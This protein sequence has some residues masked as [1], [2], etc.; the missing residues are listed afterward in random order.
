MMKLES[1]VLTP[2]RATAREFLAVVF[3]RRWIILGLFGVTMA[4][5]LVIA[6]GTPVY[7]V[8]SGQVLVRRGEQLSIMQPWRAVPND[9]EVELGSE[10]HTVKSWPV[11]ER[12][13][14]LLDESRRR[15]PAIKV[16]ETQV[17]AEVTGKSN[18]LAI[19]YR[20]RDPRV[21]ERVCDA[22][23]RAYIEYRQG[24][25]LS[26]P[27]HF[28][29]SEISQADSQMQRLTEERRQ[30]ANRTGMVDLPRQRENLI[31]L[32]G[33]LENR[34]TDAATDLAEAS[35]EFRI[36]GQ[37]KQN[38]D[39]DLPTLV[40][41]IGNES[42]LDHLK[43][44][45]ID[46]QGQIAQLRERY[47]DDAPEIVNAQAT[48]DTLHALLRREVESRYTIVRSRV[49]V[50]RAKLDAVEHDIAVVE[51]QL[52]VMPDLE[53][54]VS[55]MDNQLSAWRS[56]YLDLSK[57]SDQ[58]RINE[59]TMPLI[60]VFLLNPASPARPQ[61]TRDY[62]R[63]GLAPAFS[64]VVGVGLAFFMDGLDLT[65]HTAGQAEEEV[66]LPVLAAITERRRGTWRP[67]HKE[68]EKT[69]V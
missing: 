5:V 26:Y 47:R 37:L 55:D 67:H 64:L 65:V 20:D 38:P 19:A 18:V 36:I 59:N 9:W 44:R 54:R 30:F 17:D 23:L 16:T 34:R 61:N 53:A 15:E 68:A 32:Q 24:E 25:Q 51:S 49:D 10:M 1:S 33:M 48:L 43:N 46:Q 12:A 52:R 60:S 58:A 42:A 39:I 11:L 13:Q 8:S 66:Q 56:R 21:A 27:R 41:F 57:S 63:L 6:F 69:P 40:Q 45:V 29:D 2:Q 31:N 14:K 22:L 28:F 35:T 4:T 62:V 3:R 50:K 7:Y